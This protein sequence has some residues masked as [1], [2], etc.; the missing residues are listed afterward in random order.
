MAQFTG[1]EGDSNFDLQK[2]KGMVQNYTS[3]IGANDVRA[4]FY[5]KNK[6]NDLLNQPGCVG[7]RVYFAKDD[8]GTMAMMLVGADANGDDMI[9]GR[10]LDLGNPCPDECPSTGKSL[11]E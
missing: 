4:Y 1:N 3:G 11:A 2:A 10:I 6:I 7:I 8:N 9:N 5:G